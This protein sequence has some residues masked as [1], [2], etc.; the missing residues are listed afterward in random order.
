VSLIVNVIAKLSISLRSILY[1]LLC[2]QVPKSETGLCERTFANS[3]TSFIAAR[4]M[5]LSDPGA[6]V[7]VPNVARLS[8]H[9]DIMGI[10]ESP[11]RSNLSH[12]LS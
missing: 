4:P 12:V 10:S 9:I 3:S 8:I 1:N 5:E 11:S 6:I 2:I 7:S